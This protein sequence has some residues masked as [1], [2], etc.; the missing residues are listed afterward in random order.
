[1]DNTCLHTPD[2]TNSTLT[3]KQEIE[4]YL[5]SCIDKTELPTF[6]KKSWIWFAIVFIIMIIL[7]VV[8]WL[9]IEKFNKKSKRNSAL[10]KNKY[11]KV[12]ETIIF[13][14]ITCVIFL[15]FH[16][17][18]RFVPEAGKS[19][20]KIIADFLE[21]KVDEKTKKVI[22]GPLTNILKIPESKFFY[23]CAVLI[24]MVILSF[25]I[26]F[27]LA[28]FGHEASDIVKN[29]TF[30]F[31]ISAS[32]KTYFY[33]YQYYLEEAI[34]NNINKVK[35]FSNKLNEYV[36]FEM[37]HI[38]L[39]KMFNYFAGAPLKSSKASPQCLK[40]E[41]R[42]FLYIMMEQDAF[43]NEWI[44]AISDT[45][46]SYL[47]TKYNI[48]RFFNNAIGNVDQKKIALAAGEVE[49]ALR[50]NTGDAVLNFHE[51]E[52]KGLNLKP[53]F[54]MSMIKLGATI[55]S[56]LASLDALVFIFVLN[57]LL[58]ILSYTFFERFK[59][60]S[61]A[62]Y[63]YETVICIMLIWI[64]NIL[65]CRSI[66]SFSSLNVNLDLPYIYTGLYYGSIACIYILAYY[67]SLNS[68][69]A[70]NNTS[71]EL[72]RMMQNIISCCIGLSLIIWY[73]AFST[74]RNL[75]IKNMLVFVTAPL[76]PAIIIILSYIFSRLVVVF[77]KMRRR[78]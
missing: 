39:G 3:C 64:L 66:N 14:C 4:N 75:I 46:N 55:I 71:K 20:N 13:I 49:G 29:F 16:V 69:N 50:F 54:S 35:L 2:R 6:V 8:Y 77:K 38:W 78:K 51:N 23:K 62:K 10:A 58:I 15:L 11:K 60:K 47:N 9:V 24:L 17:P 63:I 1:M 40:H 59:L 36:L 43:K 72:S 37:E 65:I 31:E 41:C 45:N 18:K 61:K 19:F 53:Q 56:F 25:L 73:V 27:I 48:V 33:A 12:L 22:S 30:F 28:Y 76:V 26:K 32:I 44:Q 7:N 68:Y 67:N 52:V 42:E 34:I 74:H 57:I 21:V 70:G 5:Y